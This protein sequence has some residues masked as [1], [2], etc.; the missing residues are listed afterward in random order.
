MK[1][2]QKILTVK[3]FHHVLCWSLQKQLLDKDIFQCLLCPKSHSINRVLLIENCCFCDQPT[4]L[5]NWE[6][7]W[8]IQKIVSLTSVSVRTFY[9]IYSTNKNEV[10]SDRTSIRF[11]QTQKT[12]FFM[13]FNC[14]I[15]FRK[16]LFSFMYYW[17]RCLKKMLTY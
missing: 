3:S 4:Y 14:S 10:Q 13:V 2:C 6:Q 17:Q 1:G 16:F 7:S 9:K 15:N 8:S 12:C 5:F 11:S